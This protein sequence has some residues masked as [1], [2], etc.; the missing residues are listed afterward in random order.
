[1]KVNN[2]IIIIGNI[3]TILTIFEKRDRQ[4]ISQDMQYLNNCIDQYDYTYLQKIPPQKNIHYLQWY[5]KHFPRKVKCQA[6]LCF[7]QYKK[8]KII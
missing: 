7:S 3:N 2:S 6:L 4:K 1:M 8:I 5:M